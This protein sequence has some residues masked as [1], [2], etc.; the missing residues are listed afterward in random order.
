MTASLVQPG[1]PHFPCGGKN[2]RETGLKPPWRASAFILI[3]YR[4]KQ[5]DEQTDE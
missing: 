4:D 2:G 3:R 1:S 5:R